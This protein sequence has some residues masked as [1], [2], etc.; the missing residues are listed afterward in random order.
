[1][2]KIILGLVFLLILLG[3]GGFGFKVALS[4]PMSGLCQTRAPLFMGL[5]PGFID[6]LC[7][8]VI[9][10]DADIRNSKTAVKCDFTA[11]KCDFFTPSTSSGDLKVIITVDGQ[12]GKK[13]EVDT[14]PGP[15][16]GS[17]NESYV[18]YSDDSGT[19]FFKGIPSGIYYLSTNSNS[20]PKEY[21]NAETTF[22][23]PKVEVVKD[24]TTEVKIDLHSQP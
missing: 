15:H 18:K 23:I 11:H 20:F 21:Q 8:P 2:K 3:L 22:G 6:A 10:D 17:G 19:A 24:Q 12:P 14:W 13:I 7:P 9:R 4:G 16:P 5:R 1:M